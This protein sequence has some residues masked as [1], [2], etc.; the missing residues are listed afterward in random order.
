MRPTVGRGASPYAARAC[1]VGEPLPFPPTSK[2]I[3]DFFNRDDV[4]KTADPID[5]LICC[6][7]DRLR[8][9]PAYMQRQPDMTFTVDEA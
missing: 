3:G 7:P 8:Q 1:A 5:T 4:K 9:N 2:Q 6:L